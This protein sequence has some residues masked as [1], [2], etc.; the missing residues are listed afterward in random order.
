MVRAKIE[1]ALA[2]EHTPMP[3][4]ERQE[5]VDELMAEVLGYGPIEE[6]LRDPT[7]T[8]VMVNGYR[9]IY[10]ERGGKLFK[11]DK[12][13]RDDGHFDRIIQKIVGQVGRRVDESSPYVDARLPDGSRVNVILPPVSVRGGAL[14]I[15]KF[16]AEPFTAAGPHRVPD[17][18]Q[19]GQ[20]LPRGLRQ[21]PAEHPGERRYR[22]GQ[23]HHAQRALQLHP[24][25]RA[26]RHHRGR[27]RTEAVA[28][29]PRQPRV[30]AAEHRGQGR[31]HHPRPGAQRPAHAPRPHHRRAR[32]GAA[33][34]ST[35]SRP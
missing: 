13:F 34:R 17:P 28:R 3:R 1:E 26:H 23:D 14:T 10:I 2:A 30:P 5:M 24:R 35:C 8:E 19:A 12:R 25:G 6:F 20:R 11:T 4:A 9:D 32:S 27:G 21:G 18:H 7:I 29:A 31:G 16:S 15:R 22:R 33:R